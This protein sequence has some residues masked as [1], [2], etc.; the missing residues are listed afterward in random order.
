MRKTGVLVLVLVVLGWL[1][2]CGR[3]QKGPSE[4]A[5]ESL[6][7]SPDDGAVKQGE[8]SAAAGSGTASNGNP[9][10]VFEEKDF[11]FGK[12]DA[13]EKVEKIYTFR[14]TGDGPLVI[15]KVRSG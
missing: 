3:E 1:A 13:G 10:I 7:A 2:G 5:G 6:A 12:V 11:D 4:G 9:Q 8:Q 14:N 15:H